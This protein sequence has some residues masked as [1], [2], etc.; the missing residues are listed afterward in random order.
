[1][2]RKPPAHPLACRNTRRQTQQLAVESLE[3]LCL[4]AGTWTP[5]TNLLPD[6]FG[7]THEMLLSDGTVMIQIGGPA[8]GE[9]EGGNGGASQSSSS[10]ASPA[11][12]AAGPRR[13]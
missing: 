9:G 12:S 1:M 7:A 10:S 2:K 8:P 13:G 4:P 3:D 11:E 5:L 6:P